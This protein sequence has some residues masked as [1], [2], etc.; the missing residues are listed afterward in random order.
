MISCLMVALPTP[1]RLAGFRLS[2]ADFLRQTYAPRELVVILNGGDR[3]T[4]GAMKA[5]VGGLQVG[6]V[7][8]IE[9]PGSLTLGALRN[10]SLRAAKGTRVCQW[11]DDDRH[12]PDRL[13]VQ[14]EALH[15][16]GSGA[17]LL[18]EVV[19][20]FPA[21]GNL[22][23]LNWRAT[24]WRG[25]PGSLMCSPND[26]V[27]PEHGP[28]AVKGEDIA[29]LRQLRARD[30]PQTSPSL[31]LLQPRPEQLAE[32]SS[33]HAGG[34]PVAVARHGPAPRAGFARRVG[35]VRRCVRRHG[36]ARI[37]RSRLRDVVSWRTRQSRARTV[38]RSA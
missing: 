9:A 19:H 13:K 27:Y 35:A 29:V 2:I 4:R 33:S 38:R 24:E 30:G 1:A 26:V 25:F 12:H 21:D 3:E 15:A 14:I 5:H 7:R 32:R 37:E 31:R 36:D 20:A 22:Y 10:L 17:V 8:A 6:S 28:D 11:D 34:Q 18:E 23:C 16:T